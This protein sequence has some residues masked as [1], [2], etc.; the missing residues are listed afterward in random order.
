MLVTCATSWTC[1]IH[2]RNFICKLNT[3]WKSYKI[4]QHSFSL[5]CIY[6]G[7]C[8]CFLTFFNSFISSTLVLRGSSFLTYGNSH[9]NFFSNIH[10]YLVFLLLFFLKKYLTYLFIFFKFLSLKIRI[11]CFCND[12]MANSIQK[13]VNLN[14]WNNL[15]KKID[16]N[17]E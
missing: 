12:L 4:L 2:I 1:G 13:L 14:L 3:C 10:I 17:F 6:R 15:K 5:N 7:K 8:E 11:L 16:I 9:S